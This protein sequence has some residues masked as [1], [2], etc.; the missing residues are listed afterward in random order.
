MANLQ[1]IKLFLKNIAVINKFKAH[2]KNSELVEELGF[3]K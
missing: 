3:F 2:Q 1:L